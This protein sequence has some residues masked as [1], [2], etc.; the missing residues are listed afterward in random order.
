MS[1]VKPSPSSRSTTVQKP[2]WIVGS[3][4]VTTARLKPRRWR[5]AARP[6]S[7]S[8]EWKNSAASPVLLHIGQSLLHC[9]PKRKRAALCGVMGSSSGTFFLKSRGATGRGISLPGAVMMHYHP[10]DD[11]RYT[12]QRR[13]SSRGD[14]G[15][16]VGPGAQ[17]RDPARPSVQQSLRL[18][19]E[20]SADRDEDRPRGADRADHRGTGGGA[21]GGCLAP[22]VPRR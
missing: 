10:S 6:R 3:P 16:H 4:P 21:R 13:G 17:V 1:H 18:L 7:V 8:V 20:R 19:L 22:H 12:H 14:H 5:N 9:S 2:G 15:H 11:R